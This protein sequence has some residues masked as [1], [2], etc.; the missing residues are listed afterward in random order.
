VDVEMEAISRGKEEDNANI[1]IKDP[2]A[3][4]LID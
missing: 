4:E 3:F 1:E 2:Q